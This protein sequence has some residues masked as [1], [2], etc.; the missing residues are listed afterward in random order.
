MSAA[1]PLALVGMDFRRASSRTRSRLVLSA[2]ESLDLAHNLLDGG[3]A[4]GLIS[5]DTCNRNEWILASPKPR[6]AAELVQS[7][8]LTRL[9][10]AERERAEPYLL[11]GE[12]AA[13]HFF[14]VSIGQESLVQGERQIASQLFKAIETARR[15]GTSSRVLNGLGNIAGRLVN[16]AVREGAVGS[17]ARGVHSL[18]IDALRHA[19]PGPGPHPVAV[20]GL[21]SIGRRVAD[22]LDLDPAFRSRRFNRTVR[23]DCGH[24]LPLEQLAPALGEVEAVVLCTAAPTP[25]LQ[26]ALIPPREQPL[27]V[28]DIGIPEQASREEDPR[29]RLLGLDE[30]TAFQQAR[31][32]EARRDSDRA[33]AL[34]QEAVDDFAA[35]C[36][37]PVYAQILS[38][39]QQ[40]HR[41]IA[42]QEVPALMDGLDCG[43]PAA[44][45]RF[46]ADL[47]RLLAEYTNEVLRTVEE[48]SRQPHPQGTT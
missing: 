28:V 17:T 39:V 13:R 36:R 35:F 1:L 33:E 46:E 15:R 2:Q 25:L 38:V 29:W 27:L 16:Q 18:A 7:W 37:K 45:Q 19:L 4:E 44:R 12:E 9:G 22:I 34:V 21:G 6:F 26:P 11:V 31:E 8:I 30:L 43:D 40:R 5:L 3:W 32:P 14:R 20:V 42:H 41:H 48:A 24:V 10:P 47:R 23:C